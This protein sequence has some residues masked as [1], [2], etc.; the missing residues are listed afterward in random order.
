MIVL[1]LKLN[2]VRVMAN[3]P[4]TAIATHSQEDAF[5]LPDPDTTEIS[6]KVSLLPHAIFIDNNAMNFFCIVM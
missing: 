3:A 6:V 5:V 1:Y 4:V 2:N